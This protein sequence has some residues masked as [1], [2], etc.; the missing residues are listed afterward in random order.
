MAVT[1]TQEASLSVGAANHEPFQILHW[2]EEMSNQM[3][4][5]SLF[6]TTLDSSIAA[7]CSADLTQ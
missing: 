3:K 7:R 2:N 5:S 6:G 1:L 4:Q